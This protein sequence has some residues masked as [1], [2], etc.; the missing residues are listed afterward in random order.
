MYLNFTSELSVPTSVIYIIV[1]LLFGLY[2]PKVFGVFEYNELAPCIN[3]SIVKLGNFIPSGIFT[4]LGF[5]TTSK[6]VIGVS[7]PIP[8]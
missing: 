2:F 8:T 6:V 1:P 4:S 7:V 5:P 3:S